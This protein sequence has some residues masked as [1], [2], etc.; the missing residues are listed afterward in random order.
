LVSKYEIYSYKQFLKEGRNFG[1]D[2]MLMQDF[3]AGLTYQDLP[4]DVLWVLRR[5]LLDTLGVA[6]IGSKSDMAKI[7][8]KTAKSLF[9]A[10]EASSAR[11]LFDG[12]I[13]SEAGAAMSGAMTID[14]VDA[15]DGT[16]PCKGHAGSAIF[17]SIFALADGR[18]LTGQDLATYLALAY[19]IA[20]RAGLTQHATCA[21]YHTSGAWTAVGV[22]A[23]TARILGCNAAQIHEAA[24]I[25]EYHGPRSQMLRCIDHPTMVRDGVG[26]GAPTGVTAGILAKDGFT[27]APA[28]TC[29]GPHWL[30]LGDGWKLVTDTHYKPY[31]CCR[32]AHPS[33]DAAEELMVRHALSHHDIASVEIKTFH[34]ATRLA[35]HTPTTADEFAYSIAFPV[36]CMI[37]R[38]QVGI[39]E[40]DISALK[41]PEIL[42]ISTATTLI[43]DP[44]LT[45]ISDG[46]RWAQVSILMQNGTKHIAVPRTPR[47]DTDLPLSDRDISDKY[48]SFADP[49]LGSEIAGYIETLCT[50]FD[51]LDADGLQ[52]LLDIILNKPGT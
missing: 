36:A 16:S 5:S 51:N 37:V 29:Q 35:G 6:A 48:H 7:G 13:T 21:D 12:N 24:G 10:T 3:A 38:G 17:P 50:E 39:S 40:L 31:P 1:D 46:K 20:Y 18:G 26:W 9:G 2:A 22:A 49:I 42:R 41:D 44:H 19:E 34:N 8:T 27:G 45:Q 25:G 47:G 32:W 28:L 15:H 11:C 33:I 23:M 4:Q 43:D 14:S 52:V 30:G